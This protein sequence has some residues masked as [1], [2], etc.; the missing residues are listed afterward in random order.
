MSE[1]SWKWYP[2]SI[3]SQEEIQDIIDECKLENKTIELYQ[4]CQS[5][6]I[7]TY[8]V[9]PDAYITTT[10]LK[11]IDIKH[12]HLVYAST[13]YEADDVH[14]N[15]RYILGSGGETC[16]FNKEGP[17]H[18]TH[19]LFSCKRSADEYSSWMK[20]DETYKKEVREHHKRC[21]EIFRDWDY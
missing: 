14:I 5:G 17:T 9:K 2:G 19:R 10:H 12:T 4:V 21:N 7:E 8:I 3:K 11:H 15:G 1:W 18:E 16:Q 13:D 20:T 6:H